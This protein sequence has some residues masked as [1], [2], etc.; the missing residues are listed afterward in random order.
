MTKIVQCTH[1][2][3]GII[4]PDTSSPFFELKIPGYWC[5]YDTKQNQSTIYFQVSIAIVLDIMFPKV[6]YLA[7]RPTLFSP[8]GSSLSI[9]LPYQ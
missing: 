9:L 7:L 8:E 5:L 1:Y 3:L 6:K 4:P 2:F